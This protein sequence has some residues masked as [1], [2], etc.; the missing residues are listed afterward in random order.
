M[1]R[2]ALLILLAASSLLAPAPGRAAEPKMFVLG[3]G[4]FWCSQAEFER[5]PGVLKVVAGYAGG[6]T[7]NPTYHDV[8]TGTTGHAEC[9]QI[10][11]DPDQIGLDKIVDFYWKTHDPTDGTGVWPDFGNQYRPI[12]FYANDEEKAVIEKSKVEA[13]KGY[14][15]PIAVDLEPFDKFYPAEDYHQDYVKKNPNDPYVQ[16]VTL[17]KLRK[18][19]FGE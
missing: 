15:K 9:I 5:I 18:L 14:K 1:R 12:L 16:R 2:F 11:Y 19:H 17:P 13:Q 3:A 6:K 7:V 8:C 4:C 10:T